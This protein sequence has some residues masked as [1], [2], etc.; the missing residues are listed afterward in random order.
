MKNDTKKIFITGKELSGVKK[1]ILNE[2]VY[3]LISIIDLDEISN[4]KDIKGQSI[5]IS[6][7]FKDQQEINNN[8]HLCFPFLTRSLND[9]TGLSIYLQD[10]QNKE[11]KFNSD[12]QKINILNFQIDIYLRWV[13]ERK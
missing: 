5:W 3:E 6:V 11:I 7:S 12:E 10:D 8:S 4:W 2:K 13:K 1:P 9:L